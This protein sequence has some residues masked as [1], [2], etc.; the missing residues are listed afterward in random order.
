[1]EKE[2]ITVT[3]GRSRYRKIYYD[4]ILYCEADGSYC[5]IKAV[6]E[7]RKL[8][9]NLKTVGILLKHKAFVRINRSCIVNTSKCLEIKTSNKPELILYNGDKLHPNDE[10]IDAL[11]EAFCIALPNSGR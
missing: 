2:F 6:D 9:I 4:E 1:M 10:S 11:Y 8:T 7:K 5:T 3:I